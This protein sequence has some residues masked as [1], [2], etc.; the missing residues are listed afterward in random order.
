MNRLI[1]LLLFCICV[2][3]PETKAQLPSCEAT[4]PFQNVDLRGK[5]NGTFLSKS[6]SRTGHC[7]GTTGSDECTS[8]E[9]LLDTAAVAINFEIASG[10]IPTGVMYYQIE[11]GPQVPVGQPIC[12]TGPGP[13][14]VTF[15][16][17]GSNQNV[18]R[19]T[20]I[21]YPLF[22]KDDT[23]RVGCSKVFNIQAIE[24]SSVSWISISPGAP[25]QYNKYLSCTD[26]VSPRFTPDASAPAVIKYKMCGFPVADECGFN[27][28]TCDT[29]AFTTV[30]A[31]T[32]TATPNPATFCNIGSGKGVNLTGSAS[33]G[34]VPYT[35]VWQSSAGTSTTNPFF[36]NKQETIRLE[37]RDALYDPLECP[38]YVFNIPV[39]E[40]P[41][42]S[43]TVGSAQ[44]L[45]ATLPKS[46]LS[47]TV[48]NATGVIWSG[49]SGSY[50]PSPTSLTPTY[51][52]SKSEISA[53]SV[54]LTMTS[55]G[56]GAGC[57]AA[58]GTVK[59]S[60]IDTVKATVSFTKCFNTSGD[61]SVVTVSPSGGD[62]GP[63]MVS[64]D[65]G[66]TYSSSGQYSR[67]LPQAQSYTIIVKDNS[68]CLS[69]PVTIT[70]PSALT[71]SA[72]LSSFS[73]GF[74]ISCNGSKDGSINITASGGKTPYSYSWNTSS[75]SE[76]LSA[77]FAG[78][79][80]VT[81]KDANNC[82]VTHSVT[83]KQPAPMNVILNSPTFTG[84]KNISCFGLNDGSVTTISTGGD[85]LTHQYAWSGPGGFS[86][87]NKSISD[88]KAG[89]YTVSVSDANNCKINK[90]ITLTQ[91]S[92]LTVTPVPVVHSGNFNISCNGF[93]DGAIIT[94][95]AGGTPSYL[96]KWTGPEGYVSN[97]QDISS[98][99]P[100]EYNVTL[101]DANN[102][103]AFS[104]VTLTEPEPL[105][106]TAT[107]KKY[108]G[109]FNISCSGMSDG[110][111][112]TIPA[113]GDASTYTW[114]YTG[115]NGFTATTQ[116]V[117]NLQ[118]GKY[119]ITLSDANGC[120]EIRQLTIFSPQPLTTNLTAD[121]FAGGFNI[122]C[123]GKNDGKLTAV[124]EGGD[125]STYNIHWTGPG[126]FQST[127]LII[128]SL[129][130][131][132]Y[133][134][135][136]T[137]ANNCITGKEFTLK[138][139]EFLTLNATA[140]SFAGGTNI[141]CNGASDGSVTTSVEGGDQNSLTYKW[142]GP[143]GFTS[144][145]HS[146]SGIKAGTY[147]LTVSDSNGCGASTS[148]VLKQPDTLRADQ[149]PSIV[150][151]NYNISC[152]GA[153][154][155]SIA[156]T[157]AGGDTASYIYKWSGPDGFS[158]V[159]PA[160]SSLKAGTYTY[161]ITDA[162][163]CKDT[164]SVTLK[165]PDIL[166]I[167][168]LA[169]EKSGGYNISC[170]NNADGKINLNLSGGDSSSYQI[171]WTGPDGFSSDADSITGAKAG[172]YVVG[173]KDNNGCSASDTI[174]LIQPDSLNASVS[175]DAYS[176]GYNISCNGS[177]DGKIKLNISGGDSTTYL[178]DWTGPDG[179]KAQGDSLTGLK[180]GEYT[181]TVSDSNNCSY[182]N[183]VNLTQPDSLDINFGSP[184]VSGGYNISCNGSK[185]GAV[186][187]VVTGADTSSYSYQWSGPEGFTSDQPR[188]GNIG[189][190]IYTLT[191]TDINGCSDTA[192]FTV[193]EPDR[194]TVTGISPEVSGGYNI[195]CNGAT[196]GGISLGTTGGDT[197]SYTY[198]WSGPGGFAADTRNITG[199]THGKYTITVTDANGC[200]ASDTITL[201]QPDS[202]VATF[203]PDVLSG[204]FNI[205]C[206]GSS[207]GEINLNLSGGDSATYVTSWTGP[208][209]FTSQETNLSGLK[210]GTYHFTVTDSNNCSFTD[211]ITLTQPDSINI[212]FS[213]PVVSG[214]YNI[215]CQGDKN[216]S[217]TADISGADTSSYH[218]NWTGPDGF[219]SDSR[220]IDS[221]G[222]GVYT[223]VISDNNGCTDTASFAVTQPD[224]LKPG[225][226]TSGVNG[227]YN[228]SC[229]G[230]ENGKITLNST[231]GDSATYRYQ[232]TGPDGFTADT[233][234]ISGLK[235]GSYTVTIT[236][237]NGCSVS[238]TILLTQPDS[239]YAA[240]N[241]EA[242]GGDYNI[243]C[244]GASD[245]KISLNLSGG[246]STSYVM[247]WT[248]PDGYTS[249][250]KDL[251]GLKAGEYTI[252]LSDA[253][254]CTFSDTITLS[255]P[256][257]M[258][259]D[260][261]SPVVSGGFNISC[262]GKK[263]GSVNVEISGGDSTSYTYT[264]TGPDGFT[265]GNRN[266][267][268]LG[269][270]TYI[271]T[272][273]DTNN[274]SASDTLVIS[275]PDS[276][277]S[278][279]AKSSFNGTDIS[280]YG[281]ADGT[282]E[283]LVSGGDST[284]Y[285][286]SWTGPDGYTNTGKKI[287]DLKAG[288]Y[289]LN[290]SDANGCSFA[291][292]TSIVQPDSLTADAIPVTDF[293]S[294]NI[295]CNG[296]NDGSARVITT[297]GNAPVTYSWDNGA[298]GDT[299]I[300]AGAGA[301]KVTVTDANG[302][303]TADSLVLTEPT[304]ITT[305]ATAS[306]V[307]CNGFSDGSIDASVTGG[308]RDYVYLWN[309][310]ETS[311]DIDSISSGNYQLIITDKN[312]C[313]DTLDAVVAEK[314]PLKIKASSTDETCPQNDNGTASAEVT[315]GVEP[316]TYHW[317]SLEDKQTING[318]SSGSYKVT[319]KDGNN[320]TADTIVTVRQPDTVKTQLSSPVYPNGH[321]VTFNNGSDGTVSSETKGGTG[322]YTYFW[323]TGATSE[324]VTQVTAGTYTL[325]VSDGN[326]CTSVATIVLTQP[327]VLELPTGL[328]PNNDGKN[329]YYFI[330]GLEAYP[331][332][333]LIVVNRWGN[334][335]FETDN[336]K[337]DW[338]GVNKNG[339]S[340]PDGTY[341]TVMNINQGEIILKGFVEIRK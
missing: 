272:V 125:S 142:T 158:S 327:D 211:S 61:S 239:L 6:H 167:D 232:W 261:S 66:V 122:S 100:G 298:S 148:V 283:A 150:S 190:G 11:C 291:D 217:I 238:D 76:D 50:D 69:A 285:Q 103:K 137:D 46:N 132:K 82:S 248:G 314:A 266:L 91:P 264:W 183:S 133:S 259:T 299:L 305:S 105:T 71:V 65:N 230:T 225:T 270:G 243:S 254:G 106:F 141:S 334:T 284:T 209:G 282:L 236:D 271:L 138:E 81:V 229:N 31:L 203:N 79:Y 219:A 337:N 35:Y 318:L 213:A 233:S 24:P 185:D 146:I 269:A 47:G 88:L 237:M 295:S 111:I 12:I 262:N 10:A 73:G 315:G 130:A 287:T 200:T 204:G 330:K 58:T 201:T 336:Y 212:S 235:A 249:H 134:L 129:Q 267:T 221:L 189:A 224:S 187:A 205:S 120:T 276:L 70:I 218:Y 331:F 260:L 316:Y 157:T 186:T 30:G 15:C 310:G 181:F 139:P 223:L 85:I 39:T 135:S 104:S 18:Y 303:T 42:P 131:G 216:G 317:S 114:S 274:C 328:S 191:V 74:N 333:N 335:V 195:S 92:L 155:G 5:P 49:G 288:E 44:T 20:S 109:G 340:L 2:L 286:Y 323:S 41:L 297:G 59:L 234:E 93:A 115:P 121:I 116:N 34:V 14:R 173:I 182:T 149:Q 51:T 3:V 117:T 319:A 227:G 159:N 220:Q 78:T 98:L 177:T 341:Y 13:H 263:D 161:E 160:I 75:V 32:G 40:I 55:T 313:K 257:V 21:S 247:L 301:Y 320:C 332:N 326:G 231:G 279:Y 96:W 8:F 292:T 4:V 168:G 228:I 37:I 280:C 300:N 240:I 16:K 19:I 124:V 45:C 7:C 302:C 68:G 175:A 202:L 321:N 166:T 329:D 17:P 308:V 250:D 242:L 90:T 36:A 210:A 154:D 226:V 152:N 144:N 194:L 312:S 246:D 136:V 123:Q 112:T 215:S 222:A 306:D 151:G 29:V 192:S 53:K 311:E 281:K 101:T 113:G 57:P 184:V 278:D 176:G 206:N 67:K 265:S 33:G 99:Q 245:G 119:T 273:K 60:F 293:N 277:S 197:T 325:K 110:A 252:T 208:D 140:S 163:G 253:N 174:T 108:S 153:S 22:P 64:Y 156:L 171:T 26:C 126:L 179:Y 339:D 170:N 97:N 128:D 199:L 145:Q 164:G 322:I 251:T 62:G 89:N 198:N 309:N 94:T 324:N 143:D 188:I 290:V 196:D 118:A 165:Q 172:T 289:I 38:A 95:G 56:Q 268:G 214:G 296:M 25:G 178:I 1:F 169:I 77:L 84:G 27:T 180:A 28:P 127:D 193:T 241:A 107:A 147:T 256:E 275:A 162:N 102:C 244:N 63:Y 52:P 307:L 83:L 258:E 86:S 255:E 72:V 9:I 207:D 87:L 48:T 338:N 80:T 54:T 294:F 23:L 304:P 43:V